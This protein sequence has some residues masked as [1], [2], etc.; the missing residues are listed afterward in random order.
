M[1]CLR[2]VGHISK[3]FLSTSYRHV[4]L[5]VATDE[6]SADVI[7]VGTVTGSVAIYV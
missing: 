1:S 6:R 3:K 7:L 2:K 4:V 5:I